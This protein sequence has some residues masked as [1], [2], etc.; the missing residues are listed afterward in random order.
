MK[1]KEL[2][3]S[4][5]KIYESSGDV[6]VY[7]FDT[8]KGENYDLKFDTSLTLKK[9]ITFDNKKQKES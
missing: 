1:I 2:I 6:D 5:E 3:I 7:L 8:A 9:L 4:L